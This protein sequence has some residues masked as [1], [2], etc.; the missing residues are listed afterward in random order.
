VGYHG[1]MEPKERQG[2]QER[3]MSDEVR[4]MVGTIAFGLGI[5]KPTVHAVIHLSLPKSLEHYYQEAGRAGRDG[6]A[7]ECVLL[8]QKRDTALLAHFTNQI[9]D[10]NERDRAW[11]RYRVIR[12][13]AES[14][15]CR[16]E[17]LS[18]HFGETPRWALCTSCDVCGYQ[19]TWLKEAPALAQGS[20]SKT[21]RNAISDRVPRK[22]LMAESN[23]G[24]DVDHELREYLREWRRTTAR[25]Q[26]LPAFVVMHDTSLA[27]LCRVKPKSLA[28]LRG[29]YGF[30]ER[31]VA[32][33]G[34]EIIKVLRQ[35]ETEAKRVR[36]SSEGD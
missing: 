18:R 25:A 19:P 6:K 35:F 15:N 23:A 29:T 10:P 21:E 8:W 33:Y 36:C 13:F 31:K 30:G 4:I 20:R 3:W 1:Q 12:D 7:A 27:E 17:R 11:E 32:Q 16:H 26:S 9:A 22:R 5:N 24:N 14:K 2:N 34:A 28:E